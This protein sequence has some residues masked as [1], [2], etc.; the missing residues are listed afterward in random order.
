M[1]DACVMSNALLLLLLPPGRLGV[2]YVD[3]HLVHDH[4][5]ASQLVGE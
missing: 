5:V 4:R 1:S 2:L 3:H